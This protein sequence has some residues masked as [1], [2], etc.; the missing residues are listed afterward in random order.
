MQWPSE[1]WKR[2]LVPQ[3]LTLRKHRNHKR[4]R[5]MFKQMRNTNTCC[6]TT[7]NMSTWNYVCIIIVGYL[8]L[9]TTFGLSFRSE[10]YIKLDSIL[11]CLLTYLT[12]LTSLVKHVWVMLCYFCDVLF[13]MPPLDVVTSTAFMSCVWSDQ[14]IISYHV[15]NVS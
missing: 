10:Q 4:L 8:T 13:K 14:P 5:Q 12:L 9:Y 3:L 15:F 2:F 6:S 11:L 7:T 1:R